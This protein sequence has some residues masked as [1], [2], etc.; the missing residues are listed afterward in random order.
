VRCRE[1]R[2][3]RLPAELPPLVAL[4]VELQGE[5]LADRI[6]VHEVWALERSAGG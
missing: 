6:A 1:T 4:R 5:A 2:V 3:Y